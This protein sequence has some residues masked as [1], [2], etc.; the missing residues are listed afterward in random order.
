MIHTARQSAKFT[1]LVRR[2]RTALPGLPIDP[3]TVATGVLEQMWHFTICSAKRGDI[4]QHDD[5]LIAEACGW[6]GDPA[7]LVG[8]LVETGW[9]DRC[10]IH[11]LV[12][13]DWCDHAPQFLRKHIHRAGGF[14]QTLPTRDS[15]T[16]KPSPT[17]DDFGDVPDHVGL[18]ND[19]QPNQTKPNQTKPKKAPAAA[20]PEPPAAIVE[21]ETLA[22]AV[23]EWLG[24]KAE[25]RE[26]FKDRGL[27]AFY[28]EVTNAAR[29][30]G[31]D[32]VARAMRHA[33][34]NGWRGWTHGLGQ[35]A[36]PGPGSGR[37]HT[38]ITPA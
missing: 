38:E 35:R 28:G 16:P 2:I 21:N 23:D 31:P 33:M 24:Y 11:R 14:A 4:G 8:M 7:E 13:H 19:N 12:V 3:S 5:E 10:P 34:A 27:K 25:R 9:L 22:G 15:L 1:K 37:R 32:A 30:H 29:E 26:P 18:K 20:A 17:G 6:L 36:G